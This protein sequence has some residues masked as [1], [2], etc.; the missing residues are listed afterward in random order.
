M[1]Q[2]ERHE[3]DCEL[4]SEVQKTALVSLGTKG[5]HKHLDFR[6]LSELLLDTGFKGRLYL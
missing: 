1:L 3:L 4:H 6:E 5:S 2:G